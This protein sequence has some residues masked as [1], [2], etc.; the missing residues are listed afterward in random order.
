VGLAITNVEGTLASISGRTGD[1]RRLCDR[2]GMSCSIDTSFKMFSS[3]MTLPLEIRPV[4]FMLAVEPSGGD[5]EASS[6]FGVASLFESGIG[7][8]SSLTGDVLENDSGKRM[9]CGALQGISEA[10][11]RYVK[12]EDHRD[13]IGYHSHQIAPGYG[14]PPQ[15]NGVYRACATALFPLIIRSRR[16]LA[17]TE[18]YHAQ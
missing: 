13:E 16:Y 14:P 9:L 18:H 11:R 1:V 2:G 10:V 4:G 15:Q 8:S 17:K 12:R 7:S 6:S 5:T 3:R